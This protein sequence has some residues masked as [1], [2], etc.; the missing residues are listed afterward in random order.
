MHIYY[1]AFM[2]WLPR[3]VTWKTRELAHS[4]HGGKHSIL[5]MEENTQ[6]R[7]KHTRGAN[8]NARQF[9]VPIGICKAHSLKG[10][11]TVY[12][13]YIVLVLHRTK[14]LSTPGGSFV[15]FVKVYVTAGK[16]G[17]PMISCYRQGFIHTMH[18]SPISKLFSNVPYK[19]L[20]DFKLFT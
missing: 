20:C 14:Y 17:I 3:P 10:S 18:L 12:V 4:R 7:A 8:L 15:Y 5:D 19:L 2:E 9:C 11:Y 1:W 16:N 13:L 6:R